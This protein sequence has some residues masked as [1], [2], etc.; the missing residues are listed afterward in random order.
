MTVLMA[1][2]DLVQLYPICSDIYGDWKRDQLWLA[3][4]RHMVT[5]YSRVATDGKRQ[6]V[7]V[8]VRRDLF[9][10]HFAEVDVAGQLRAADYRD[11]TR[12]GR[13]AWRG[14]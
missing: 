12:A 9:G 2:R 7:Q 1:T 11:R 4:K 6:V 5:T 14:C 8:R 10:T 13:P 3:S